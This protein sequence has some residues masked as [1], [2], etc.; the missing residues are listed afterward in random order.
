MMAEPNKRASTAI[1][2][3]AHSDHKTQLD[4]ILLSALTIRLMR[5]AAWLLIT[6]IAALSLVP[7]SLRPVTHAGHGIEHIAIF[8]AAGMAFGLGYHVRHLYLAIGLIAFA[9]SIEIA[10][11]WVPGRHARM[12]DFIIDAV[13]ACI[14]VVAASMIVRVMHR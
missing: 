2:R 3:L 14:G 6:A 7:P 9:G 10:Q 4:Q 11:Y 1:S 5:A 8:L 12:S 13:S